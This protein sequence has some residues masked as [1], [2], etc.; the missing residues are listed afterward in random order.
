MEKKYVVGAVLGI[1]AV[2]ALAL[3]LTRDRDKPLSTEEQ[4]DL[5]ANDSM[6]VNLY[7]VSDTKTNEIRAVDTIVSGGNTTINPKVVNDVIVATQNST[8]LST[9]LDSN[10]SDQAKLDFVEN[11]YNINTAL[12]SSQVIK[13]ITEGYMRIS[14]LQSIKTYQ[15]IKDGTGD[16]YIFAGGGTPGFMLYTTPEEFNRVSDIIQGSYGTVLNRA[17][18]SWSGATQAHVGGMT[19]SERMQWR[20]DNINPALEYYST[21]NTQG[22]LQSNTAIRMLDGL[23]SNKL[24]N[25]DGVWYGTNPN[26]G[27]TG[28]NLVDSDSRLY[29][30]FKTNNISVFSDIPALQSLNQS[31]AGLNISSNSTV[32]LLVDSVRNLSNISIASTNS[33]N[34]AAHSIAVSA[35]AVAASSLGVSAMRS[36]LHTGASGL[37]SSI[38]NTGIHIAQTVA[39][40]VKAVAS[41]GNTSAISQTHSAQVSTNSSVSHIS[42][43]FSA[44][45]N[46]IK[47]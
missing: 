21:I 1:G 5:D 7:G 47:H 46:A 13:Q 16:A 27:E 40:A 6:G 11:T 42:S 41:S 44:A 37:V 8:R 36:V 22:N 31:V 35:A 33:G 25:I 38:M 26:T 29:T 28:V 4:F 20:A 3:Y 18:A 45:I 10:A 30:A 39:S 32:S 14:T 15:D 19:N 12:L 23:A 9:V 17:F 43:M 24:Y 2:T 34:S